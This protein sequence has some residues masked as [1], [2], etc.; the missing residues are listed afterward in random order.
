MVISQEVQNSYREILYF[1]MEAG[2]VIAPP[3]HCGP[4]DRYQGT[5]GLP[6]QL[7]PEP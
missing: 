3:G 4:G 6:A 5:V 7:S 1:S 2:L